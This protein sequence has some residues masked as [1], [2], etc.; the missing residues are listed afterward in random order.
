MDVNYGPTLILRVYKNLVNLRFVSLLLLIIYQ[1]N[2]ENILIIINLYNSNLCIYL[3]ILSINFKRTLQNVF[4][5]LNYFKDFIISIPE[6]INQIFYNF[7]YFYLE[8]IN[9]L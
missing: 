7:T 2:I 9:L 5:K 1:G 4:K 6:I 8:N 3:S